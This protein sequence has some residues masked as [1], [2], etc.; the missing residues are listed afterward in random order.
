MRRRVSSRTAAAARRLAATA[1]CLAAGALP[2]LH[3]AAQDAGSALTVVATGLPHPRAMAWDA[4]GTLYAGLAGGTQAVSTTADDAPVAQVFGAFNAQFSAAVVTIE[5]GCAVPFV[6]RMPSIYL[7]SG[8]H[9]G[10][11]ALAFLGGGLY[12]ANDGAGVARG[13]PAN[14]SGVYS[15][16]ASGWAVV[17]NLD[18]WMAANPVANVPGDLDP[19]G[20]P[21]GMVS[22][23]EALYLSESN[24]GQILRIGADGAITRLAD[25]SKNHPVPTGLSRDASGNFY[26]G[27]LT[28]S[29]Y[30]DGAAYVIKVAPDGS[31]ETVWTGLT[32]VTATAVGPDGALYALEMSTGNGSEPP[33]FRRGSGRVVRMTGPASAEPVLTGLDLPIAMNFGPDGALYLS[34]PAISLEANQNA[35]WILRAD[36]AAA[37]LQVATDTIQPSAC[38]PIPGVSADP[39]AITAAKLAPAATPSAEQAAPTTGD[40]VSIRDYAFTP[41]VLQTPAGTT[42]TWTN[43]DTVP[44]TVTAVDKSFDSGN[45]APG[46][47]FT[48][49]FTAAGTY[50]YLCQYHGGM[51]G[52]VVVK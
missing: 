46:A 19:D 33:F 14:P 34:G 11:S 41:A 8:W 27:S 21:F 18:Y 1:L 51:K 10:V 47:V 49:T 20:E 40:R 42:V 13:N 22:D 29:P 26:V 7:D 52:S 45:L 32:M 48:Y 15:V 24:S 30:A 23:G 31:F 37:P 25:L 28:S 2:A 36:L 4:Q 44:H 39:A 3:A 17:G 6:T 38:K 12:A 35:G 16:D 9:Q 5:A 50:P 43:D